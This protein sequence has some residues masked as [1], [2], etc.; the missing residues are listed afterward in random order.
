MEDTD[1]VVGRRVVCALLVLVVQAIETR[2]RDPYGKRDDGRDD[3]APVEPRTGQ[4]DDEEREREPHDVGDDKH[5]PNEP[6]AAACA[7]RRDRSGLVDVSVSEERYDSLSRRHAAAPPV[8]PDSL[9][10]SH[11]VKAWGFQ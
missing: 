4:A 10:H 3:R 9:L 8:D 5:A 6:A 11:H 1:D 2:D 7:T